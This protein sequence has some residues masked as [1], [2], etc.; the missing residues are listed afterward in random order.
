MLSFLATPI[1]NLED[2]TY[3]TI[4]LL[5]SSEVVLCEDTRVAKKLLKLLNEKLFTN[6]DTKLKQFISLH[7]HN[8]QHF[9]NNLTPD[10][11]N[12]N[13]VYMSDAGT[14]SISDPGYLLVNYCHK[15]NI[16]FQVLPGASASIVAV[17]ASGFVDKEFLFVGFL[18]HKKQIKTEKLQQILDDGFV[19]II[20]ES[21]KRVLNLLEQ[22]NSLSSNRQIFITKELTKLH[23][24][25]HKGTPQEL[26]DILK[27][28][29][30]KGE[31]VVV[32][33]KAPKQKGEPIC[34]TDI[35][36]L[37]L[38]PK[39]KAKLLSKLAGC[40]TKDI[41][42]QNLKTKEKDGKYS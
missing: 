16:K 4:K 42:M 37:S 5:K 33:D 2:I 10:F 26:L 6:I 7:S 31:W 41:Y 25:Y 32:I 12:K 19:S 21:P 13:I 27:D 35:E 8:E 22:I 39:Q 23:E 20:Y 3:R 28:Q 24:Q 30:T 34:K 1:G 29:T 36:N 15:N 38:P 18:P 11:F 14:P 9:L 40:D 17:V